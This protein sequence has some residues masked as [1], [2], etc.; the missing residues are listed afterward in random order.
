MALKLKTLFPKEILTNIFEYDRTYRLL[1]NEILT[2]KQMKY[3]LWELWKKKLFICS[4]FKKDNIFLKKMEYILDHHFKEIKREFPENI[5]IYCGNKLFYYSDQK[6]DTHQAFQIFLSRNFMFKRNEI[7]ISFIYSDGVEK[8]IKGQVYTKE[9]YYNTFIFVDEDNHPE[10]YC[11][12][13]NNELYLLQ[14][15]AELT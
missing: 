14:H 11:F 10:L 15:Y 2:S 7:E 1:M 3:K 12:H 5:V 6:E 8:K 4:K 9:Q 13:N